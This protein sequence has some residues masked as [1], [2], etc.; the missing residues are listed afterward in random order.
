MMANMPSSSTRP[1]RAFSS[2]FPTASRS[3]KLSTQASTVK[4]TQ[5]V[6]ES[7]SSRYHSAFQTPKSPA[8]DA[9]KDQIQWDHTWQAATTFL[10][11]PQAPID[12]KFSEGSSRHNLRSGGHWIKNPSSKDMRAMA[13]LTHDARFSGVTSPLI[14]WYMDEVRRHFLAWTKPEATKTLHRDR[15]N[16]W[17]FDFLRTLQ[18]AQKVYLYPI[19]HFLAPVSAADPDNLQAKNLQIQSR[20]RRDLHAL[21]SYSLPQSDI[22]EALSTHIF[23]EA[24]VVLGIDWS[25]GAFDDDSLDD[26]GPENLRTSEDPSQIIHYRD[27]ILTVMQMTEEVGLGGHNAQRVF[28]EVMDLLMTDYVNCAY[29][30]KWESPSSV[31]ARLRT[32]IEHRFAKLILEALECL[33]KTETSMRGDTGS[34]Y[35]NADFMTSTIDKWQEMGIERLG[36]LRV[37]ELF[38]VIVE[39]DASLGAVEDLKQYVTNPI[40]RLH[41]TSSFSKA[42]SQRL[43]QPGASTAEILQIYI[44]LIRAFA[45]LD[46]KGVL[47]DRIAR[48]LRRYLRDRDDTVKVIV[49]GLLADVE[50]ADEEH[51]PM[52]PEVLVEL[53]V[54]LSRAIELTGHDE[55]DADFDWDD[56][57]WVPDPVDAGPDY[58]KIK[59]S[60]V[61]GSMIS[62]FDSKDVFIKEFQ[63]VMGERLLKRELDLDKEVRVLELL[64]LRFGESS[65][66]SCEVMLR[67]VLDSK[68]VDSAI[69]R[70]QQLDQPGSD[71]EG[72]VEVPEMHAKIL[73]R[74]FWPALHED[75]FSVPNEIARVRQRYEQGFE[76]LKQSRKLTWLDALGQVTVEL[77]LDDRVIT[78]DVQ[79][80]QASVIYAFQ[81]SDGPNP[82]TR[83]VAQL[84]ERLEMEEALVRNAL[85]YWVA[86]MVLR[87]SEKDTFTVIETLSP[88]D[89]GEDQAQAAM[90]AAAEAESNAAMSSVKSAE[91]VAMEKMKVFWQ[92]IV[93]MLTNQ[94]AMPLPRIVMMLRFA[95]PGGFPF[96][97]EELKDFLGRMVEEGKLDLSG[98]NYR[99]IA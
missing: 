53:A 2:V 58:K 42:I 90:A 25:E 37:D 68:R 30:R 9:A 92:F 15:H 21:V 23:A 77:D 80:W 66:Q 3:G 29:A 16:G 91:D 84:I 35:D 59:S 82:Q 72:N 6:P 1:K 10:A 74:L 65:L 79:T 85:T 76:T 95:M 45:I 17:I 63:N 52:T 8:F 43:L 96:G 99:L 44:S 34:F 26:I 19:F 73:S 7:P 48:P 60:D 61:I 28:A 89:A 87:E 97:D 78:D 75:T 47:L 55:N 70:E 18:N 86:K 13:S 22:A 49:S 88:D 14:L 57:D 33:R 36:R 62:L 38:S 54:E 40:T 32:W 46:P 12:S 83:T 71:S 39:W 27:S 94:G 81:G 98:G 41:L 93:G 31:P 69:R 56:M 20:F 11:L 51:S 4:V 5:L 50:T 67:D 64:K 24:S